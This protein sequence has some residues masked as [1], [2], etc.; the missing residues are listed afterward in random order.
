MPRFDRLELESGTRAE[1]AAQKS[2]EVHDHRYWLKQADVSRRQGLYENTLR[3]YSRAL[4]ENKAAVTAWTGQVQ[5]LVML[6][7]YPEGD[8]WA[9]KALEL[10]KGNGDLLAARA[11]ALCRLGDQRQ[12]FA[13]CDAALETQGPAGYRWQVRGELMLATKQSLDAH[14]FDKAENIDPD[15]LVPLESALICIHYRSYAR[16]QAR[17]RKAVDKA[18]DQFHCWYVLGVV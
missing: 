15:W 9:R 16:A 4:E 7:E 12:A 2:T 3:H 8:L 6:E 5:M 18:P 17:A 13:L 10:F 14:C 1:P 11:Q